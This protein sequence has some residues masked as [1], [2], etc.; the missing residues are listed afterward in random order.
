MTRVLGVIPARMGS[1]RFPGKPF[2]SIRGVPML[3]HVYRRSQACAILSEVVIATCDDVIVRAAAA[4]GARAVMTSTNH[5]RASDRVAEV[6]AQ[7][8]ADIVV[9]IQGDEPLILPE[10]IEAAVAPMLGDTSI[11]CVNLAGRIL[12]EYE[13]AD[14]NTIKL[15]ASL[16]GRALYFSREAIPSAGGRPFSTVDWRKQVCVIPFRRDALS[17]FASLPRGRLEELESIDMLR[18]LENGV[19]VHVVPIEQE[20]HAVD[21][22]ADIEIV[23]S[24][25]VRNPWH[26]GGDAGVPA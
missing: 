5:E 9:M 20:T 23:T 2:A 14:R 16:D 22:P 13:L 25:L 24:L 21:V 19:D 18:F 1:T 4:F 3:E 26:P 10:M 8:D 17:A 7:D 11:R 12:S 15:V 6:A